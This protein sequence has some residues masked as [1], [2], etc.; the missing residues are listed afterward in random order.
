ML[1]AFCH[2]EC[3]ATCLTLSYCR[4]T[5]LASGRRLCVTLNSLQCSRAAIPA[6]SG[7][8]GKHSKSHSNRMCTSS[9][10]VH[11]LLGHVSAIMRCCVCV[12]DAVM[13]Q[14]HQDKS[15]SVLDSAF[16]LAIRSALAL[17]CNRAS[18][19]HSLC[20]AC[21]LRSF[22]ADRVQCQ[23]CMAWH[24][25]VCVNYLPEISTGQGC[26]LSLV[27]LLIFVLDLQKDIVAQIACNAL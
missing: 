2:F 10:F 22:Q 12:L 9:F 6:F 23:G 3:S 19:L 27:F 7:R 20:V 21:F 24:H 11:D 26:A 16:I 15:L 13:I 18:D 5:A 25:S 4:S 1:L 14:M 8:S 17:N